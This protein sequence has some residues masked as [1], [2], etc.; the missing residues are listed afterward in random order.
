LKMFGKFG[1]FRQ[2]FCRLCRSFKVEGSL[3]AETAEE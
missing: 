3:S 1:K 2:L